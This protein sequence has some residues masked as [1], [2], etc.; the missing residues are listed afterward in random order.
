[1]DFVRY[2]TRVYYICTI[3]VHYYNMKKKK[4]QILLIRLLK[5]QLLFVID[6]LFLC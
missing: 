2:M 5:L 4:R 6:Y 1:M 3:I